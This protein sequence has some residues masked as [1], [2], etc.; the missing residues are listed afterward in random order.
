MRKLPVMFNTRAF[1]VACALAFI[2]A[3]PLSA[4]PGVQDPA[5][6]APPVVESGYI[7]KIDVKKKVLTVEG[8]LKSVPADIPGQKP[9]STRPGITV[10]TGESRGNST[11][12]NS[13]AGKDA[14]SGKNETSI[15][16]DGAK[17][18]R[19]R[20]F[21]VYIAADTIIQQGTTALEFKELSVKDYVMVVGTAKGKTDVV[22]HSIAV[23]AR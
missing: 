16:I 13:V 6:K 1:L 9:G 23:S 20:E 15:A 19:I 8:F 4:G 7:T 22:A 21:K 14:Q 3:I 11:G 5:E 17:P 10:T 18:E 12:L 2:P